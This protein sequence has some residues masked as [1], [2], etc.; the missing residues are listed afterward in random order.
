M[1]H[2]GTHLLTLAAA[3]LAGI[4]LPA[5]GRLTA[6]LPLPS[7][8]IPPEVSIPRVPGFAWPAALAI[9]LPL[10][11]LALLW[12]L[13][14][15]HGGCPPARPEEPAPFPLWGWGGLGLVALFWP[16]AWADGWP[17][18]ESLRQHSFFPLWMGY[19][20]A[21]AGWTFRRTGRSLAREQPLRFAALFA[22]S[23]VFWWFFEYLNRFVDN[24]HY[25]GVSGLAAWEYALRASLPFSTVLPAVAVTAELLM[26]VG[27]LQHFLCRGPALPWLTNR[28]LAILCLAAGL[29]GLA[30]V[31]VFPR[32]LYPM[33]WAG[34]V[35]LVLGLESL[36][37][38]SPFLRPWADGDWR[39]S[40]TWMLA[41]LVC[42]FFWEMW[43]YLSYPKW[44][45]TVPYVQGAQLFEMP[46]LGYVGYLAFGIECWLVVR[47]V[48]R[49][50][51]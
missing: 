33:L 30:L 40:G 41:A 39:T 38:S 47:L 36:R 23:G 48:I 42:G 29:A 6:G 28:A 11:A 22:I 15:K 16:I 1:N 32:E 27:P 35:L 7:L 34:P 14:P 44:I 19:I 51:P 5:L 20:L 50:Q 17:W 45:Y 49:T 3:L 13:G 8:A 43:N 24:W 4:L 12:L 46:L 25:L 18:L 10:A 9:L 31:G 26:T 2:R 21:V 37:G